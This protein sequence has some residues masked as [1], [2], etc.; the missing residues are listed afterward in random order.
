MR[1]RP[2]A[3]AMANFRS[4]RCSAV[5]EAWRP[6]RRAP[7]REGRPAARPSRG[8]WLAQPSASRTLHR[9]RSGMNDR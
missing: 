9:T 7:L 5:A 1:G 4:W 8:G 6:A 2:F 3:S